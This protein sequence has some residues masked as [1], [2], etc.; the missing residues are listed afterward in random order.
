MLMN[1][2]IR[3]PG[4]KKKKLNKKKKENK[5]AF[6]N[7]SKE[8]YK[9]YNGTHTRDQRFYNSNRATT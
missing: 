2:R 6:N 3:K 8:L 7:H 1:K 5:E 9:K 4:C